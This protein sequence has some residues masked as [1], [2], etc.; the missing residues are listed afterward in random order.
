MS[1]A[2]AYAF[3]LGLAGALNPCGFPLLP[4]YLSLFVVE[5]GRTTTRLLAGLRAGA[6]LTAGFVAVF[7]ILGLVA[8]AVMSV[9]LA[10]VPW[11]MLLVGLALAVVGIAGLLGR[12]PIRLPRASWL[13]RGG[14]SPLAVVGYGAAYALGSLSCSLPLFLA[15]VAG[16]F[17]SATPWTGLLAFLAY[18]LG[19][20]LFVTS[21]ALVASLAGAAV[22]RGLRGAT[23][24]LPRIAGVVC[25]LVGGYLLLYWVHE[26]VDP[27]T[28]IP[29]IAAA[30]TVQTAV[31]SWMAVAAL[32]IALGCG[33]LVIA[34]FVALAA[35]ARKDPSHD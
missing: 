11:V 6:C 32:P 8:D 15:G 34:A 9:V 7:G 31:A 29:L 13:F 17:T 30:Q 35:S 21:A 18:A 12:A 33:L 20:G 4:A 5:R 2:I 23:R 28:R 25:L 24:I 1:A 26:L 22:V 14:A 3:T 19:M 27:A 16:A 10:V